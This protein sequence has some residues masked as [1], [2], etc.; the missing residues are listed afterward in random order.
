MSE[1]HNHITYPEELKPCP[2]C[3]GKASWYYSGSVTRGRFD[4]TIACSHCGITMKQS[5][6]RYGLEWLQEKM[7]EK[8]NNRV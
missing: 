8:W 4:I 1:I 5:T 3:G 7:I 2:F 6:L